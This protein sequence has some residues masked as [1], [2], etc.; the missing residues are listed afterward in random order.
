MGRMSVTT[1]ATLLQHARILSPASRDAASLAIE[2]EMLTWIGQ[3]A[4][5]P[6]LFPDATTIDC[7]GAWIAPPFL[8]A[9]GA[10]ADTARHGVVIAADAPA[11]LDLTAP[12]VIQ[13]VLEHRG[14]GL[15]LAAGSATAPAQQFLEVLEQAAVQLGGPQL[16]GHTPSLRGLDAGALA[17]LSDDQLAA[18]SRFG[19]ALVVEPLRPGALDGVDVIRI[20]SAG[21]TIAAEVAFE[22]ELRPWEAVA[23]LAGAGKNPTGVAR[24]L[25]PRAAFTAATRGAARVVLGQRSPLG[26][27]QPGAPATLAAWQTGELVTRAAD[28][29]VQRWSTDPRSG[30]PPLPDLE[31]PTP[32]CLALVCAG[33]THFDDGLFGSALP[34]GDAR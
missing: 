18:L 28:D 4:P 27:L 22:G 25:S 20:A 23:A 13:Q 34:A 3:D 6:T 29:A 8:S 14:G 31:G 1:A 32:R 30:V 26:V 11:A 10:C 19:A 7:A 5:G 24:A 33:R 15:R 21:V 2:G 16:A 9:D 12:D 17:D